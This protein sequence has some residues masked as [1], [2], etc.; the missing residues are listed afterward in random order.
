MV[1]I[2][3]QT[4]TNHFILGFL[5]DH[6]PD[7]VWALSERPPAPALIYIYNK[8]KYCLSVNTSDCKQNKKDQSHIIHIWL[9]VLTK[10]TAMKF[11]T[12]CKYPNCMI[13]T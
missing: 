2:I 6:E 4:F 1:M 10:L 3:F 7:L 12:V 8:M 11:I 5:P 13:Q 9:S